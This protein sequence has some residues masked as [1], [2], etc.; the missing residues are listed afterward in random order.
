M[1]FYVCLEQLEVVVKGIVVLGYCGVN[2]IIFYKEEVM[3][4]FDVIDESVW[5]IGVVNMIVNDNGKLIGYNIDGIGYVCLLKEEVVLE[6]VGKKIVVF[7]V[8]GVVRG[9]IYVLVLEKLEWISILNC[10]VERVE[11]FVFDLR[12]YG[13]GNI[14]GSGMEEVVVVL[15]LVDIVINIM[16]VGMYLYIDDVFVNLE[17]IWKG[18]V[19]SDLIYN[20]LEICL[21]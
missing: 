12:R 5:L 18:V 10:I 15:V 3:K 20:L 16:V 17:L 11:V 9:V 13:L 6:F 21:L 1:L 4:Y 7:G 19:V 2:V 8:G 14:I